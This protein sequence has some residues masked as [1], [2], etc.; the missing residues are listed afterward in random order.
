MQ[1]IAAVAAYLPALEHHAQAL[2]PGGLQAWLNGL[3]DVVQEVAGA[4]AVRREGELVLAAFD[5]PQRAGQ[6]ALELL[7]RTVQDQGI[8]VALGYGP[9]VR[10]GLEVFGPEVSLA[11]R[12]VALARVG[13]ALCTPAAREAL[14]LPEGVG[15]FLAPAALSQRF[16]RPIHVLRDYR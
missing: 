1:P 16:G 2:G 8:G 3:L 5:D 11:R 13:E 12:L 14:V 10:Q 7:G 6:V 9:G 4:A 15:V